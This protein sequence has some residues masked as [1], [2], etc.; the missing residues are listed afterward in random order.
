MW[1]EAAAATASILD[2]FDASVECREVTCLYHD[3]NWWL[4]RAIEGQG[5]DRADAVGEAGDW[6]L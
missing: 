4:E 6:F 5:L 3:T 1:H 2:R